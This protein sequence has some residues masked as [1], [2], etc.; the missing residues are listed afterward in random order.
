MKKILIIVIMLFSIVTFAQNKDQPTCLTNIKNYECSHILSRWSL[1]VTAGPNF[2][3]Y[4]TQNYE[5]GS[6]GGL[7]LHYNLGNDF[8]LGLEERYSVNTAQRTFKTIYFNTVLTGEYEVVFRHLDGGLLLNLGVGA[9]HLDENKWATDE[10]L[11]IGWNTGV[12]AGTGFRVHFTEVVDVVGRVR[13]NYIF[14][15]EQS[16][17]TTDVGLKFKF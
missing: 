11:R 13:L 12:S 14:G 8:N 3:A 6:N 10:Q 1:D 16:F 17:L 9:Y 7:S 15:A 4:T 2:P 5:S